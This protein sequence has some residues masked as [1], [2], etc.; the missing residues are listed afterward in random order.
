MRDSELDSV[1]FAVLATPDSRTPAFCLAESF[2]EETRF[3][4]VEEADETPWV[5]LEL[6]STSIL[7]P[8]SDERLWVQ[9][10]GE[11][12]GKLIEMRLRPKVRDARKDIRPTAGVLE[13]ATSRPKIEAMR[14][15]EAKPA[16]HTDVSSFRHG[17]SARFPIHFGHVDGNTPNNSAPPIST[18][19]ITNGWRVNQLMSSAM[20]QGVGVQ[21]D[22]GLVL[23]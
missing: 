23:D 1:A 11:C 2:L 3:D 16:L 20:C 4:V 22:A 18:E 10:F 21:D 8:K 5:P 12:E 7:P 14:F 17:K 13:A 15:N 19:A 9:R 6:V